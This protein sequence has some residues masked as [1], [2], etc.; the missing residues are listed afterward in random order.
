MFSP[1]AASRLQVPAVKA[2]WVMLGGEGRCREEQRGAERCSEVQRGAERCREVQGG[3]ESAV[4]CSAVQCSAVQCSA[5]QCSLMWSNPPAQ[6]LH[7]VTVSG[8][9]H[10]IT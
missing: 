3:A 8:I 4:Q 9:F 5:V 10:M 7:M 1:E 2:A 6:H